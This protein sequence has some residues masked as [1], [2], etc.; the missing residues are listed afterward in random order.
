MENFVLKTRNTEIHEIHEKNRE[1]H[2]LFHISFPNLRLQVQPE[3]VPLKETRLQKAGF[4]LGGIACPFAFASVFQLGT[5][6]E[7][8]SWISW[9][10]MKTS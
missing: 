3:T 5:E 1:F 4:Y 6:E 9:K 2:E 10:F 7:S 8:S